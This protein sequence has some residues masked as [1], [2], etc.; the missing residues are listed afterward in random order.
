ME[1]WPGNILKSN[2]LKEVQKAEYLT[3]NGVR[4]AYNPAAWNAGTAVAYVQGQSCP[5]LVHSK[6]LVSPSN[7]ARP[8]LKI[9]KYIYF[10]KKWF[11]KIFKVILKSEL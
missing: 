3:R 11:K 9:K 7:L 8:C 6:F 4:Q 2:I 5:C 10:F 1:K